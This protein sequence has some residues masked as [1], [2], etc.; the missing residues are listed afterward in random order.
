ALDNNQISEL[1][2]GHFAGLT[3]LESLRAN[4]NRITMA[5]FSDLEGS[6]A[7]NF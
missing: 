7:F 6:N 1:R 4:K 3:N 2:P 5:D